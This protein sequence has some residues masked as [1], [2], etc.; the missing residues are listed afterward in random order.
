MKRITAATFSLVSLLW[1]GG[2]AFAGSDPV[3][4]AKEHCAQMMESGKEVINH[5]EMRHTGEAMKYLR[6]MKNHAEQ[7]YARTEKVIIATGVS[8]ENQMHG[9]EGL[10]HLEPAMDG[11]REAMRHGEMG[12]HDDMMKHAKEAMKHAVEGNRHVKEM[13]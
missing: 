7:C 3:Q 12:H 5:G 2:T 9:K 11:I 1:I 8:K 10:K 6:E 13:R 4:N